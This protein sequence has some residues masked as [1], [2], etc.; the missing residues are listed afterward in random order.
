MKTSRKKTAARKP[1]RRSAPLSLSARIERLEKA[2]LFPVPAKAAV[3]TERF[4]NLDGGGKP[5]KGDHVAVYDHKTRLTWT[6]APL[7]AGKEMNHADAMKACGLLNLLDYED[8]R[9]PTI[10]ELLSIVDYTRCD[11]AVDTAHFKGPFGWTWSSTLVASP[12]GYAWFVDLFGGFSY[13][14]GRSYLY[15]VRAVRA[16]Q[17]LGLS[18]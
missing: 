16:G 11:P 9:A 13:R 7:G 12:S 2:V 18:V 15:L 10:E 1:V 17:Q 8:W 5:T 6:A 4:V 3:P 14:N